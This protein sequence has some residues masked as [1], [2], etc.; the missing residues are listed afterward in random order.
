MKK[1]NLGI[2][3]IIICLVGVS[4]HLI[5]LDKQ[6][7]KDKLLA[8]EFTKKYFELYNKYSVLEPKDRILDAQVDHEKYNSYVDNMSSE[9]S[10][11]FS[12]L[13]K[14][15]L[16]M[17]YKKRLDDQIN[18]KYMIYEYNKEIK[19]VEKCYFNGSYITFILKVKSKIDKDIKENA[20]FDIKSKRYVGRLEK[21]N[22][23]TYVRET[24]CIEK[25]ADGKYK[26]VYHEIKDD[27]VIN[28]GE[29]GIWLI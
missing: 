22:I 18:G 23:N 2:I 26:I 9:L 7:E 25:I 29:S 17:V 10:N 28:E 20:T 24:L 15:Y 3:L 21:Q 4:V 12:D 19:E 27:E 8:L 11:Y 13:R 5:V 1:I 16:I 6:K 14:E